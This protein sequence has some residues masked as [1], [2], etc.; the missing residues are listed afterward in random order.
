MDC[1]RMRFRGQDTPVCVVKTVGGR[2][3]GACC[4]P[5]KTDPTDPE[6]V[7]EGSVDEMWVRQRVWEWCSKTKALKYPCDPCVW[8]TGAER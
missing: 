7:G 1:P 3:R 2:M 8:V 4:P 6:C 5:G